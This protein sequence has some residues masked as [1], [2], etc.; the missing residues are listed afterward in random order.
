MLACERHGSGEPLVLVHGITHR[1]QAWYPVLDQLAEHR[2]VILVDLP[3][4]G[5]SPVFDTKGRPVVEALRAEFEQFLSD[6][7]LDRP[8]V[9]GN[10]L[11]G[12]VALEA[13]AAGH[14]RSVTAL[15]PAGFWR[16][17]SSFTYT[18][19]I[20]TGAAAASERLNDR[21]ALLSRTRAGRGLMYGLLTAHPGRVS[22]DHARGDFEAFKYA[23]PALRTILA[24]AA[25]FD[26]EI[27]HHV[28]VTVAWAARDRVLPV[29]QARVAQER[30]PQAEHVMMS[31]VG[32]V[33]MFDNPELVAQILM[34][35]S[36][37]AAIV[38]P[39]SSALSR[40][41]R[42]PSRGSVATA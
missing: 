4:H 15:S 13:G 37:P 9:A 30:L 39:I 19:R 12:R 26:A 31:G 27:P 11:G 22:A 1:R 29:W 40:R 32:H 14:A 34:R 23:R 5:Q 42:G 36:A 33:P 38:A 7:E 2:E 3:G 21:A 18:R 16:D 10:S 20:F 17:E 35:G 6:Q 28:P 24:A 8:H 41:G 25:P